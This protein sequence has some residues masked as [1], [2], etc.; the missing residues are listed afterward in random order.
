VG[1]S[2]APE[3][4]GALLV[5]GEIEQ[6]FL[7]Q[8]EHSIDEKGRLTIPSRYREELSSG[9]LVLTTGFEESLIAL[10]P[11]LFTI[12]SNQIRSKPI[13]NPTSRQFRRY[14]FA[15]AQEL[16]I[17]KN[18][19]ILLPAFLRETA[20]LKENAILVG[21]GEYFELWSPENWGLQLSILND[22]DANEQRFSALDLTTLP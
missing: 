9:A 6:M 10:T 8:Y 3:S 1:A 22:S 14:F 5:I 18:G 7:G 17:D 2:G 20:N 21:N 16:E 13:T 15:N 4:P 11:E 12:V 19:R